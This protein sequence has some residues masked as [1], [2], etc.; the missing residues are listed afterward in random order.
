MAET[1]AGTALAPAAAGRGTRRHSR[2]AS[3]TVMR[4]YIRAAA[5]QEAFTSG[6]L[7]R[8]KEA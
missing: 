4:S 6:A 5:T 1:A 8:R 7:W 3:Q 2:H